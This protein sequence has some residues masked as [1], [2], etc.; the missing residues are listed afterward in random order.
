[1][2][3]ASMPIFIDIADRKSRQSTAQVWKH[4]S[5]CFNL[6]LLRRAAR[7]SL[8][9]SRKCIKSHLLKSISGPRFKTPGS[10]STMRTERLYYLHRLRPGPGTSNCP[11][12][13]PGRRIFASSK[14]V[15]LATRV[16]NLNQRAGRVLW[17]GPLGLLGCCSRAAFL[18]GCAPG[19]CWSPAE[20]AN[21][22]LRGL[23][24]PGLDVTKKVP[25]FFCRWRRGR[26]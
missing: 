21:C 5:K 15:F 12:R 7:I 13:L 24:A 22:K 26:F 4:A 20:P 14:F 11:N 10:Q 16:E 25:R 2:Q 1:M 23:V 17:G 9:C 8:W 3:V 18:L 19:V 6:G